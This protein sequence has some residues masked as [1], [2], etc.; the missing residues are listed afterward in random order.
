MEMLVAVLNRQEHVKPVLRGLLDL[1]I[2]G[3]TVLRSSGM[4]RTLS[5]EV[6]IFGR[7]MIMG[8]DVFN[9]TIFSVIEEEELVSASI[10][11]ISRIVGD[12]NQPGT[13][14]LFTVPVSRLVSAR[15]R[16]GNR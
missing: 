10:D 15:S 6:P 2:S 12:L 4:G 3:A 1:G 5:D 9:T 14:F 8:Q 16:G 7:Q 13:G 11:V